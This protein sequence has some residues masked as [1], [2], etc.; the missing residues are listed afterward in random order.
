M[1][2]RD[3]TAPGGSASAGQYGED[4]GPG[5]VDVSDRQAAALQSEP[6]FQELR[7]RFRAFAFP[8]TAA[9]L[10]WYMLLIVGA[11]V[12]QDLFGREILGSIN[13]G[14]VFALLQFVSTFGIA[15]IYSRYAARRLDPLAASLRE[16]A[17][18]N[19]R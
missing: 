11:G 17:E 13:V 12:A 14:Y 8:W 19:A 18:R 5:H 9:F 6:E 3:A 1:S 10:A 7:R 15:A 16:R 4:R 2:T